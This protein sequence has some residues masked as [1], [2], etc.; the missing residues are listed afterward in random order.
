MLATM[1]VIQVKCASCGA[2]LDVDESRET[3]TC[4]YC[5]VKSRIQR[6]TGMFRKEELVASDAPLS[7]QGISTGAKLFLWSLVLLPL[8]IVGV[9]FFLVRG[10]GGNSI[11]TSLGPRMQWEGVGRAL[12]ADV[13]ADGVSDAIGRSRYVS[14]SDAIHLAA[15]DG[16]TG[17]LLFESERLGTYSETYGGKASIVGDVWLFGSPQGEVSAYSLADGKRLW[18]VPVGEQIK[19][20]CRGQPAQVGV[21]SLD[22]K[23]HLL[24]LAD[25][26]VAGVQA[27]RGGTRRAK[28]SDCD[29]LEFD[30]YDG[31]T[32]LRRLHDF[33]TRVEGMNLGH[34]FQLGTDGPIV[35]GGQKQPGSSIPMVA[36]FSPDRS[37]RFSTEVPG[38]DRLRVRAGHPDKLDF[39]AEHLAVIFWP[40]E[41][42]VPARLA[43]FQMQDGRRLWETVLPSAMPVSA[44]Q[45]SG[46]RV[47]V[48]TWGRMTAFAAADGKPLFSVGDSL[49]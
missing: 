41:L 48:T 5:G 46:D 32:R 36:G 14:G 25:G 34:V 12:F 23:L 33:E 47:Y 49:K 38:A 24:N 3:L 45:L 19:S 10:G 26:T 42:N 40:S 28:A 13:N 1:K 6:R 30:R 7:V 31:D 18:R 35:A 20:F 9:T 2:G 11:P 16:K 8:L 27:E 4:E 22:E 43:V 39:D 37:L 21:L 44:V 15:L 29:A 17:S